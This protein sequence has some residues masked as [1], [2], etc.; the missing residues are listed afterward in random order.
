MNFMGNPAN[1]PALGFTHGG[2]FHADDVFSS[3]LLRI[4]RP[5]IR[6]YRGFTVPKGFSGIAYDIGDGPFDHH[7]KNRECRENGVPYA[8]FGLLWRKY[9]GYILSEEEALRFDEKFVQPL[10]L[11]DN[12]GCGN[13]LA[14]IIGAFNPP[15]DSDQDQDEA[16]EQALDVAQ[17]MLA[18]KLESLAAVER[19]KAAVEAQLKTMQDGIVVLERY[20]P[21]KP[22]LIPSAAEFVIFPSM[23]GGYSLQCIPKDF[24]GKTGDKVPLPKAWWG[25]P[26]EELARITGLEDVQ[27]CHA[28]GFMATAGSLSSAKQMA[29]QAQQELARRR[30]Q[31]AAQ[32]AANAAMVEAQ[33]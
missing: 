28:S 2:R 24:N 31:A 17:K 1:I 13:V 30:Q 26:Q 6:I 10:D 25:R 27:F 9:G 23:R 19:G 29:M 21:W 11:D 5:D 33:T 12:T 14:G 22:V 32:R 8:A 4:L 15:W 7:Q 3:A 20:V 18:H 16:F